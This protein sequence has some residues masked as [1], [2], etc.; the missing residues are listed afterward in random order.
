MAFFLDRV[1]VALVGG[2]IALEGGTLKTAGGRIELG[3]VAAPSL[4]SLTST[5]KG[6]SLGYQG[7]QNFGTIQLSAQS[8]V[9]ASGAGGGDIQVRGG[10]VTLQGGSRIESSNLGSQPGGTLNVT[11]SDVVE[12]I[13]TSADGRFYSVLGS[14]VAP[15]ATQAGSNITIETRQLIVRDGGRVLANTFG[16]G[17]GGDLTVRAKDSVEVVSS[18]DQASAIGAQVV[19]GARGAG[20]NITLETRRLIVREGAVIGASTFGIGAGGNLTVRAKDSVEVIGTS[21]DGQLFSG[22]FSTVAP[23]ATGAGGHLSIETEQLIAR[24]GSSISTENNGPKNGGDLTIQAKRL[25]VTNGAR[26]ATGSFG[27]GSSGNLT[28]IAPESV[29]L[30]GTSTDG[31]R[32]SGLFTRAFGKGDA[33]NLTINTARLKVQDG[34]RVSASTFVSRGGHLSVTALDSVELS[35]TSADGEINSGLFTQTVGTGNAGSLRIKTG[36]FIVRDGAE[37]R[38]SATDLFGV[39][40]ALGAAG[41]IEADA[42]SILLDNGNITA[43][44]SSGNG[45]NITLQAEDFL[46]M[47]NSSEI[48]T[49]AGTAQAGGDGGNITITTPFIVA[50]PKEDSDITAN[51]YTGR[52]GNIQVTASDLFGIQFRPEDTPLSDITASSKFG[53]QGT[54]QINTPGVDPTRGLT[55]LPTDVT[56]VS[57]QIAQSCPTGGGNVAQNEFIITGRGGLP[58]NPSDALS[59]DGVWTDWRTPTAVSGIQGEQE[60]VAP[61]VKTP[62]PPIVEAN[63]WVINDKDEVVLTATAPMITPHNPNPTPSHC[64]VKP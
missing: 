49:S 58:D 35:G 2:D 36:R 11:A 44:T 64:N 31:Q 8:A 25:I 15:R 12:L 45:G 4:V 48:S 43:T 26:V 63:G 5:N 60:P 50:V 29:E 39:K 7:V 46:L 19:P 53:L 16:S 30:S 20:G 9:D 32:V 28:V 51:A 62:Q 3:S 42:R 38:V 40:D 55:N 13:G 24:D 61:Q 14:Q 22:L 10:R 57:N 17:R 52:G 59:P 21:A 33:G 27:A 1:P 6:W 56:D 54:V 23:G 41:S 34:A 18:P 37:V 47:R